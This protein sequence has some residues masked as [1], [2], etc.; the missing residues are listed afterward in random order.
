MSEI[1]NFEQE[2]KLLATVSSQLINADYPSQNLA[3]WMAKIDVKTFISMVLLESVENLFS[4]T[5]KGIEMV[6][7]FKKRNKQFKEKG[8]YE[9]IENGEVKEIKE[10]P[11]EP[12]ILNV[13]QL[14][15]E[16]MRTLVTS[17]RNNSPSMDGSGRKDII[18]ILEAM[19]Q[20]K[21]TETP[22]RSN[23][24]KLLGRKKELDEEG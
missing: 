2:K 21:H 7:D 4:N 20:G 15:T 23:W 6:N 19:S 3:P 10:P 18:R 13:Y 1:S 14:T 5:Q 22:K 24:D 12:R 9:I 11:K 17:I 8:Y 16:Y